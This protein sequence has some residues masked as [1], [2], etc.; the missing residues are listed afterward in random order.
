MFNLNKPESSNQVKK[1]IEPEPGQ[2]RDCGRVHP[3]RSRPHG[4]ADPDSSTD[5]HDEAQR[6]PTLPRGVLRSSLR[7]FLSR[8][9][10]RR[11]P[12]SDA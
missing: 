2:K 12:A 6:H 8:L 9:S 10:P 1:K 5:P 3:P 4:R 7:R 11:A